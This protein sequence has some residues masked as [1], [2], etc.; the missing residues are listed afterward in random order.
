MSCIL[1][2]TTSVVAGWPT[3]FAAAGVAA[4]SMGFST[5]KNVEE[6]QAAREQEVELVMQNS[7]I[8]TEEMKH[9]EELNLRKGDIN[10][11]IYKDPRGRCAIHISGEGKT[12]EQLQQEG[13]ELLNRIK[14][15]Y[16]YQKVVQELKNKGF[17]I[18]DEKLSEAGKIKIQFRKYA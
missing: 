5:L 17:S 10:V 1:L 15:Q 7:E 4:A 14:Q 2:I 3:L 13:T 16:A 9:D 12:K 18:T 6:V 11:R 8:I